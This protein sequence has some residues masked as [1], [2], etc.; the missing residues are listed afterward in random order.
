M[1][2]TRLFDKP[3]PVPRLGVLGRCLSHQP[4]CVK[5]LG[6]MR[7]DSDDAL[8]WLLPKVPMLCHRR[9]PWLQRSRRTRPRCQFPLTSGASCLLP[10]IPFSVAGS[11]SRALTDL[12]AL[13]PG[14]LPLSIT[15]VRRSPCWKVNLVRRNLAIPSWLPNVRRFLIVDGV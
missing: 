4:R 1:E 2:D 11:G 9:E 10:V 13:M 6:R 14:L 12:S 3:V 5:L 7:C 15:L 8:A